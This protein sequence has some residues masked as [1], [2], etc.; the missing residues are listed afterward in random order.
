MKKGFIERG[1]ALMVYLLAAL[2]V[3]VVLFLS[4]VLD[5]DAQTVCPTGAVASDAARV[6]WRNPTENTD[7]SA[8]EAT[9]PTSLI[10]TQVRR[11]VCNASGGMGSIV[12]TITVPATIGVALFTGLPPAR[13]CFQARIR[14]ELAEWSAWSGVADKTT[15]APAPPKPRQ[16]NV[17]V[18]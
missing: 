11:S 16:P 2:T 17:T 9:G 7:G 12:E 6:C 10:E 5:A 4:V 15:T 1:G 14:N 8:I 18:S 13:H 3:V